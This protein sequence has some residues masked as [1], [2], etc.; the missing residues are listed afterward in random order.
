MA[1]RIE[2][3]KWRI[4]DLLNRLPGQCWSHHVDWALNEEPMRDTGLR[5]A[6]PWRPI[7]EGCRKDAEAAGRCYCG[8]LGSDGTVLRYGQYVCVTRMPGRENDRLCSRP[9]GHE[10]MH[11]CG[12][13]S[14]GAVNDRG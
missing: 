5:S 12:S 2:R 7:T 14:W 10:G 9:G 4:A 1:D 6:L 11:R 8:Y 3:L 13:T